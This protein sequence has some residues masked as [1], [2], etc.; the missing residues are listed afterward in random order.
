MFSLLM[1]SKEYSKYSDGW[2]SFW[3]CVT[4]FGNSKLTFFF[5]SPDENA[6]FRLCREMCGF[7]RAEAESHSCYLSCRCHALSRIWYFLPGTVLPERQILQKTTIEGPWNLLWGKELIF[8]LKEDGLKKGSHFQFITWQKDYSILSSRLPVFES[9][10]LSYPCQRWALL[11]L[12][13]FVIVIKLKICCFW[14]H[15]CAGHL[16]F[17]FCILSLNIFFN[18]S[19]WLPSRIKS[20]QKFQ[21][22]LYI[23]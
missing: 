22:C 21:S 6:S 23:Y 14:F 18:C 16:H 15:I 13:N 9:G 2:A 4:V 7:S 20:N 19:P 12:L 5:F 17:F 3:V 8:L 11:F 10:C 1:H